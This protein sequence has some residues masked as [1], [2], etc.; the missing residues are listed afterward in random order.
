M[1]VDRIELESV[2]SGLRLGEGLEHAPSSVNA[3][4]LRGL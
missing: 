3:R 4:E 2:C 1:K